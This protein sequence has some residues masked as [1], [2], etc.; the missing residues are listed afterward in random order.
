MLI[1]VI[2]FFAFLVAGSL[3][4]FLAERKKLG[5]VAFVLAV[6]CLLSSLCFRQ[7]PTGFTGVLT[8]FG[9]VEENAILASGMNFKMPY[10]KIILLDNREQKNTFELDAFSSDIQQTLIK[11]DII[12]NVNAEAA[13][14]LYRTVGENYISTIIHPHLIESV[15]VVISSYTAEALISHRGVISDEIVELMRSYVEPYGI[16]VISITVNNIDFTDAFTNAI[17]AKQVAT[18]E[19]LR[20]QTEQ[21]RATMETTAQAERERIAAAAAA[22]V[23]RIEADARAYEITTKA[24]AEAEGNK[25]I[26]ASITDTLIDYVKANNWDGQLPSTFMGEGSGA[27][28]V[29]GVE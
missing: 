9:K 15:K 2:L 26:S 27:V 24:K 8:T 18:Q 10:Q 22:E 7:V 17:E 16:N 5:I 28:P 6:L 11:G 4:C 3:L 1:F 13:R 21:E 25:Q 14:N 19:K 12:F 20:A 29:I 23:I